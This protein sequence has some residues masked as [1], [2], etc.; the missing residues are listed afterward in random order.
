M[1]AGNER[2]FIDHLQSKE[3]MTLVYK[4]V[5]RDGD[6]LKSAL[7]RREEDR[8][9]A[10][11]TYTPGKTT[12]PKFGKIFAFDSYSSAKDF[13]SLMALYHHEIWIAE[14]SSAVPALI[15]PTDGWGCLARFKDYW[16]GKEVCMMEAPK[17]SVLCPEI[18]LL[19]KVG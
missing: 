4:V 17:G 16:K 18:K 10:Q 7:N 5:E 15:V 9:Q 11:L 13:I 1:S 2:E 3:A 19:E 6:G 8:A 12:K 14:T